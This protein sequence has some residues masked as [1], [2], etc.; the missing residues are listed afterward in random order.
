MNL[1][2][3]C[4]FFIAPHKFL[5]FYVDNSYLHKDENLIEM[6]TPLENLSDYFQYSLVPIPKRKC[7]VGASRIRCGESDTPSTIIYTRW[8]NRHEGVGCHAP[9]IRLS[10]FYMQTT[11]W[12]E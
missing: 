4:P 5:L 9:V 3:D 8:S 7:M 10:T 12:H 1:Y 2:T 6:K 11:L